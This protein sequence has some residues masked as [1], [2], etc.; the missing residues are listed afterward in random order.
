MAET[1]VWFNSKR[2]F[3]RRKREGRILRDGMDAPHF[4]GT[5]KKSECKRESV[6]AIGVPLA[7]FET[8]GNFQAEGAKNLFS[9]DANTILI[10]KT[11]KMRVHKAT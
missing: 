9:S 1:A 7:F 11:G 2:D 3:T 4:G 10:P 8:T 5:R 6:V